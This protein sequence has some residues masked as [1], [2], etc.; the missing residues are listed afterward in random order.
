MSKGILVLILFFVAVVELVQPASARTAQRSALAEIEI[1]LLRT[2][3]ADSYSQRPKHTVYP[4]VNATQQ[5]ELV[6]ELRLSNG[7]LVQALLESGR[8]DIE[9]VRLDTCLTRGLTQAVIAVVAGQCMDAIVSAV[10][11]SNY[12]YRQVSSLLGDQDMINQ[13]NLLTHRSDLLNLLVDIALNGLPAFE[14]LE[15][16]DVNAIKLREDT[17]KITFLE[18]LAKT[19]IPV[20]RPYGNHDSFHRGNDGTSIC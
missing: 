9:V 14:R 7:E 8:D 16:A 12:T 6:P 11:D 5:M 20:Y 17:L 18:A 19:G 13:A 4:I 2:E 10:P 3:Q 15:K 1:G